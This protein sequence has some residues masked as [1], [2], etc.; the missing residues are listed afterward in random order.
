M[1]KNIT[2]KQITNALAADGIADIIAA[3]L[4]A[5]VADVTAA[6][7]KM[8]KAANRV[9]KSKPSAE[10][11]RNREIAKEL[12]AEVN[13]RGVETTAAEVADYYTDPDGMP[14]NPRKVG[15]LLRT[16]A[17]MG[18]I[19]VSP[20]AWAVKHYGPCGFEFAKKPAR[21]PKKSKD[22]DASDSEQSAAQNAEG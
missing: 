21:K 4:N 12:A 11:L 7:D 1:T 18:L 6:I 13:A 22:T 14:L 9:R 15:A 16:A 19:D 17:S 2:R 8:V 3:N 20:E 10:T 5:D